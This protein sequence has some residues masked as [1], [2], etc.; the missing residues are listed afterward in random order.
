[1]KFQK[2]DIPWNKGK[3][4]SEET[5]EKDR[6]THF[7]KPSGMKGKKHSEK[8]KEKMRKSHIGRIAWNKGISSSEETRKK[9]RGKNNPMFGKTPWNKGKKGIMPIPWNKDIPCFEK[10]KKKISQMKKGKFKGSN[11]SNWKG[12]KYKCKGYIYI[13]KPKHPFA[14]K[15]GYILRSHLVMEKIIKR[16]L[17]PEE[18]VHHKGIK[19][20]IGSIENKQDDRPENLRL[21]KNNSEH[22]KFHKK[23]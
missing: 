14:N 16:Y 20:P 12:G 15:M 6:I 17:K 9:M 1:M 4:M 2:G 22:R 3:P 10:T 7:G 23:S 18:I 8:T 11:S 21:F 5:K 13:L 19:Y